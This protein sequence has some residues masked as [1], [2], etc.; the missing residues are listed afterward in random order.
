M[1]S[2]LSTLSFSSLSFTTNCTL[3]ARFEAIR[4][5]TGQV[6]LQNL[7]SLVRATAPPTVSLD[8]VRDGDIVEWYLPQ[9]EASGGAIG[10]SNITAAGAGGCRSEYCRALKWEG[11]PDMAGIGVFISYLLESSILLVLMPLLA[12]FYFA[13]NAV[14]GSRH[15]RR[16]FLPD[17]PTRYRVWTALNITLG[18]FWLAALLFAMGITI[19]ALVFT[20]ISMSAYTAAF[21]SL[22]TNIV[23]WPV[24]LPW[25]FYSPMA[26]R[27]KIRKWIITVLCILN[28]VTNIIAFT[29]SADARSDFE[30][31]CFSLENDAAAASS[32]G[33][34]ES[35]EDAVL[36]LCAWAK[37]LS[38][39]MAVVI[40]ASWSM[41]WA[42][43]VWA[44]WHRLYRG[45]KEPAPRLARLFRIDIDRPGR[46]WPWVVMG[47]AGILLASSLVIFWML[48][49][50]VRLDA[51]DSLLDNDWNFG[52]IA[53]VTA[54]ALVIAEIVVVC[55]DKIGAHKAPDEIDN[56]PTSDDGFLEMAPSSMVAASPTLLHQEIRVTMRLEDAHILLYSDEKH[57]LIMR[58]KSLMWKIQDELVAMNYEDRGSV[59]FRW[60]EHDIL[61]IQEKMTVKD[62]KDGDGKENEL[63]PMKWVEFRESH[64]PD[65]EKRLKTTFDWYIAEFQR[66]IYRRFSVLYA[67]KHKDQ[68]NPTVKDPPGEW[69]KRENE[70]MEK[71]LEG[72]PVW[73]TC[74][75]DQRIRRLQHLLMDLVELLDDMAHMQ[76]NRP[77]RRRPKA[78]ECD[79][80][81]KIC[82][83]TGDDFPWRRLDKK[84]RKRQEREELGEGQVNSSGIV[85]RRH[86]FVEIG[87]VR[88]VFKT[89]HHQRGGALNISIEKFTVS[90][91]THSG[92]CPHGLD[93]PGST[94]SIKS[95]TSPYWYI[96]VTGAPLVCM[97]HRVTLYPSFALIFLTLVSP[98]H[99]LWNTHRLQP[100][101]F[102]LPA[103]PPSV[104][105]RPPRL[106]NILLNTFFSVSPQFPLLCA[107]HRFALRN[108][109]RPAT[110]NMSILGLPNEI[111]GLIAS[112]TL[113]DEDEYCEDLIKLSRA[114]R[115]FRGICSPIIYQK[116]QERLPH[117]ILVHA[118]EEHNLVELKWLVRAARNKAV[119]EVVGA[120]IGCY[121]NISYTPL[122]QACAE[123]NMAMVAY[124]LRQG[125]QALVGKLASGYCTCL[126]CSRE[127]MSVSPLHTAICYGHD[128]IALYLLQQ[129]A[130]IFTSAAGETHSILLDCAYFDR[131]ALAEALHAYGFISNDHIQHELARSRPLPILVETAVRR[132]SPG[133]LDW[134]MDMGADANFTFS[135]S[136][137]ED[138]PEVRTWSQLPGPVLSLAEASCSSHLS[139]SNISGEI[140]PEVSFCCNSGEIASYMNYRV[141]HVLLLRGADLRSKG[142]FHNCICL[143]C[144]TSTGNEFSIN[145]FSPA[146]SVNL[147]LDVYHPPE[148]YPTQ[149]EIVECRHGGGT[150]L[151]PPAGME[152]KPVF[153]KLLRMSLRD[154]NIALFAAL[155]NYVVE[156]GYQQTIREFLSEA[157]HIVAQMPF[158]QIETWSNMACVIPRSEC[159]FYGWYGPD[160]YFFG[161]MAQEALRNINTYFGEWQDEEFWP[162]FERSLRF[163]RH[164][165]VDCTKIQG[166]WEE[167]HVDSDEFKAMLHAQ[168]PFD[169][170]YPECAPFIP[171][172]YWMESEIN[173]IRRQAQ[174][175]PRTLLI[176]PGG[177]GDERFRMIH[178]FYQ[179][180]KMRQNNRI[181]KGWKDVSQ[182]S[183]RRLENRARPRRP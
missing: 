38:V 62:D 138:S 163:M 94:P 122:H 150:P 165:I 90:I 108:A 68:A 105:P 84:A 83:K 152:G 107:Q 34:W 129:G 149:E 39:T 172:K 10:S 87:K 79:C 2:S 136:I 37:G 70:K 125:G 81:G 169:D 115:L 93:L 97:S 27:Q 72:R 127:D 101:H 155:A 121:H 177:A 88:Y 30:R 78:D 114:N 16:R 141:L 153:S 59:E 181:F 167:A 17:Y 19:S 18:H 5:E 92:R 67:T 48:R 144:T 7:V 137:L 45:R 21:S 131:R 74:V 91:P 36:D 40:V 24:L 180:G 69:E 8:G 179:S 73:E 128:Y 14:P 151:E 157:G 86:K 118:V 15:N 132:Q 13:H 47:L 29:I 146:L 140:D 116:M 3:S 89:C 182:R 161:E 64:A 46:R 178:A 9:H 1:A 26:P 120:E 135:T 159:Y 154:Q 31:L 103:L 75:P 170:T 126:G 110:A 54:W 102:N 66:V 61:A 113:H 130:S 25:P 111:L 11:D 147:L 55:I 71:E 175:E 28:V 32:S 106:V 12:F 35:V 164:C 95:F 98:T 117:G 76:F 148:T 162:R 22:S 168:G 160:G 133:M 63:R 20:L 183:W 82:N 52:Q 142:Q 166:P 176:F 100:T 33:S 65:T 60:V 23:V 134:L 119:E 57:H 174:K 6:P 50:R 104:L 56:A 139:R 42:V 99:P 85:D 171:N 156:K 158:Y 143:L 145:E 96:T 43:G 77:T 124:L 4:N 41:Q 112:N 51:G 49:I 53:S 173:T 58:L 80:V 44:R 123:G 109:L